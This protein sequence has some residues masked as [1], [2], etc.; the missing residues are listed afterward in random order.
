MSNTP[1]Q[2]HPNDQL[3]KKLREDTDPSTNVFK[4][5]ARAVA[6]WWRS[7]FLV[8]LWSALTSRIIR[9]VESSDPLTLGAVFG[10]AEDDRETRENLQKLTKANQRLRLRRLVANWAILF[11]IIQLI[12][13]NVFFWYYMSENDF[14]INPNVVIAWLSAC[15]VEVIGILVVI[16]RSLFPRRDKSSSGDS[17]KSQTKAGSVAVESP[18]QDN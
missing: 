3:L 13:S 5:A 1:G 7:L 9:A 14:L 12:S 15:V 18:T 8:R 11:V 17:S 16:A 2:E 4:R 6:R 10:S